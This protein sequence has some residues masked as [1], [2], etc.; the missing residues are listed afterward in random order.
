MSNK[1]KPC[2]TVSIRP[3]YYILLNRIADDARMPA[4]G[5]AET[6]IEREAKARGIPD[7]SDKEATAIIVARVQASR[8]TKDPQ[9]DDDETVASQQFTF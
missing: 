8:A 5:V 4:R 3:R 6:L 7:I 2:R 9:S 1:R